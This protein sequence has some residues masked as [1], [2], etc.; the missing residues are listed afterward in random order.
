MAFDKDVGNSLR[1]FF[2]DPNVRFPVRPFMSKDIYIFDTPNGLG[3]Q[4]RGGPTSFLLRGNDSRE[5]TEFLLKFLDGKHTLDDIVE[6]CP[7]NVTQNSLLKTLSLFHTKGLLLEGHQKDAETIVNLQ[8][9]S[10]T[11]C[12]RELLFWERKLG[13]TG[14]NRYPS[15]IISKIN[16]SRI[17]LIG[18]GLFGI[19]TYDLLSRSGC[20]YLQVID[21]DDNGFFLETLKSTSVTPLNAVHLTTTSLDKFSSVFN[22]M[23]KNADIVIVA[24]RN[25]PNKFFEIVNSICLEENIPVLFG[26][27]NGVT[28]EIGPYVLPNGSSCYRCMELRKAS[29]EDFM[30]EEYF[31]QEEIAKDRTA[32]DTS[33]IG[34]ALPFVMIG[35]TIIVMEAIR[36]ISGIAT[37]TLLNAVLTCDPLNGSFKTNRILRVPRCPDCSKSSIYSQRKN[38]L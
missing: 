37:P 35:S 36:I 34:E 5:V 33:P 22:D 7:T 13:I 31:F 19:T 11:V 27:D 32:G 29:I 30:I 12:K 21:W 17:T 38:Y 25:G 24:I 16:S 28:F 6:L 10:E 26:N 18:S 1:S 14:S 3:I 23:S 20:K 2:K 4:F 15:D 8:P 9:K